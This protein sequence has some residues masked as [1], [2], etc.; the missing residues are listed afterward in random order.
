MV[1]KARTYL[2]SENRK[3]KMKDKLE[4]KKKKN[5]KDSTY[6]LDF[7]TLFM[8]LVQSLLLDMIYT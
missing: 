1:G 6:L 3:E 7:C 2:N 8:T 5:L 4:I